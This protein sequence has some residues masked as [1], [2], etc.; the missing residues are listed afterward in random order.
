MYS[1]STSVRM[2]DFGDVEVRVFGCKKRFPN[3]SIIVVGNVGARNH[4]FWSGSG[5]TAEMEAELAGAI[6]VKEKK[7]KKNN[8]LKS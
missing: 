6:A 2:Q 7:T 5:G 1:R 4:F 8:F 3:S